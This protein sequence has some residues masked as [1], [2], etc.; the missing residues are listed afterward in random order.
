[1][2]PGFSERTFEFC[3]NAEY[4]QINAALLATHPHIP[5]QRQEKDL[6]Y[7]VEFRI[8]Q[9]AFTK[10]VF[11][12]HK[13]SYHAEARAGRN[14]K[15]YDAHGGPY[16]RFSVD[17]EQHNTLCELSRTKGNAFYCAPRFNLRHE[18]ESHFRAPSIAD[19]S[20]L[21]DPL[22]V[23]EIYDDESHNITYARDGTNPTLHSEM[24]HFRKGI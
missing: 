22:D 20:I 3:Y 2:G 7:D 1:M 9:G 19:N 16:F 18:L 17:N 5:S 24:R 4:C 11:F 12:Q 6:G 15:F 21:L 14:A 23:G 8:R 13:V 10:S